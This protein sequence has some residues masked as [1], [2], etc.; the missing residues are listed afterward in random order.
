MR[1]LLASVV[2]AAATSVP[3]AHA[4]AACVENDMLVFNPPLTMTSQAGT[5]TLYYADTCA[6]GPGL[7]PVHNSGI[8]TLTYSG[9]CA[10]V[11]LT[12]GVWSVVVGGRAYVLAGLGFSKAEVLTPDNDCPGPI[13]T[14]HGGGVEVA[15][16]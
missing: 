14:A 6:D 7:T 3:P 9:T 13:T 2:L 11:M 15:Y 16:S 10:A 8:A 5:A 1:V 4:L 12:E